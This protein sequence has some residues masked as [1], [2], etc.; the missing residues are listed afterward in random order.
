MRRAP[1]AKRGPFDWTG[2]VLSGFAITLLIVTINDPMGLGWR[3]PV[4]LAALVLVAVLFYTFVRWELRVSSPMLE[5]RLFSNRMLSLGVA[6][7]LLGFMGMTATMFL[8]PIYLV[9][10]RGISDDFKKLREP[11]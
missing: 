5:L 10:L 11:T 6:T 4:L 9:S 2:A 7:R 3:S 1:R 8:M